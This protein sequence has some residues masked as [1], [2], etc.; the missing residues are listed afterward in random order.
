MINPIVDCQEYVETLEHI[1]DLERA[2]YS[3][4]YDEVIKLRAAMAECE[5]QPIESA[6]MDGTRILVRSGNPHY[7]WFTKIAFWDDM[8]ESM[9]RDYAWWVSLESG[10][11]C[12]LKNQPTHWMP[13]PS[14][15]I[16]NSE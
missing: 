8:C 10:G 9:D 2:R 14:P 13:L 6:P 4:L 11:V 15:T 1:V 7:G 12:K 5:W 16:G 3:K